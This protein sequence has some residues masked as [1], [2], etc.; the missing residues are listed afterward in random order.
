MNDKFQL[1][2]HIDFFAVGRMPWIVRVYLLLFFI[3]IVVASFAGGNMS[4]QKELFDF[5]T[6]ILKIVVG[7]LIG[8]LSSAANQT[9]TLK[10]VQSDN[11]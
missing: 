5:T 2:Q 4:D 10:K 8:V 3:L 9:F 7:A 11:D 1:I 6:E